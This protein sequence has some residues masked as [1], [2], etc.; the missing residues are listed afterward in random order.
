MFPQL[1]EDSG[2]RATKDQSIVILQGKGVG[3]TTLVN[4][5]ICFRA[6][7][8]VLEEWSRLGI[9]RI[10]PKD[11]APYYER[12]EREL[13]VTLMREDEVSRNDRIFHLAAERLGLKPQRFLHNRKDCIG[14][15]FCTCGCSYDR[16]MEMARTYIPKAEAAGASVLAN[17][18]AVEIRR[19][20]TH[21]TAVIAV[22]RD[23]QGSVGT[24]T[25]E[26][27]AKT[28]VV[29]G[30]GISTP[31][32]LL[33]SGFG[34]LNSNIGRHLTLHPILPNI[35]IMR[36]PVY[37]YEGIPQCE[38]VDQLD[39]SDGGGYLLEGIGAHPVLVSLTIPTFGVAHQRV[40]ERFNYFNA[41]YVM[42][43]DRPQ[44][45]VS[46]SRSGVL[47]IDYRL[48]P[49]DQQSLREG[50]KLSAKIYFAAGA[51]QVSLNH[52]DLPAL[53]SADDIRLIDQLRMEPNRMTLFAPHQMS[54]CRMGVDPRTSVTDSY[55]KVHGMEN[56]Y[57]ADASLF[58]TSLGY[59]PQLTI[60]AL[61]TRNAEHL[62]NLGRN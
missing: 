4:H 42:V 51:E 39:S 6:P 29:A 46:V 52:E 59:N 50:M 36:E 15:G 25:I 32:L 48:H 24:Q 12:V 35:G 38:Y 18:E 40:M 34:R 3:G 11:L 14:C 1:F 49:W 28:F 41:H 21:A 33:R 31:A 30:G 62:L 26:V 60:M 27:R 10:A 56:L 57:I 17:T 5:N 16:K 54:S 43:K 47:S 58:P 19:E 9:E 61:A 55:G 8:F 7:E 20:S 45:R 22:Q 53:R 13:S 2:M 23:T 44:G 37:F